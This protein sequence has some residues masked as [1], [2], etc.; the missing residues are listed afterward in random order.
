[1]A[2]R[3]DVLMALTV[4]DQEILMDSLSRQ[5]NHLH[6]TKCLI[7]DHDEAEEFNAEYDKT[8]GL[9]ERFRGL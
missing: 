5:L 1:M 6:K 2:Q 9:L 7:T 4:K 3:I 8:T